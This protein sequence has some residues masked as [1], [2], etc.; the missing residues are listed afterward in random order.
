MFCDIAFSR[1][2]IANY[3]VLH[4]RVL[5][6]NL[7]NIKYANFDRPITA[8]F[9]TCFANYPFAVS[10]VT[11]SLTAWGTNCL[12]WPAAT[13]SSELEEVGVQTVSVDGLGSGMGKW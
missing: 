1:F 10:H 2:H 4:A 12:L 13:P 3:T 9:A 8:R 5:H 11:R 6:G 7:R